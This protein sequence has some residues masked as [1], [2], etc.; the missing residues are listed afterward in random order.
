MG[1]APDQAGLLACPAG[2]SYVVGMP[3]VSDS[4]Q[5][6][7]H[8]AL[9][10]LVVSYSGTAV[11]G[12][13]P[14][15]HLGT[16]GLTLPLIL[17][18]RDHPVVQLRHSGDKNPQTYTALVAGLRMVPVLIDHASS[19]A[20]LSVQ[21]TP[22]GAQVLLGTRPRELID[23]SVHA[24]DLLGPSVERL[25]QRIEDL[26]DWPSRFAAVDA[27]LLSRRA[28]RP[29]DPALADIAWWM[30]NTDHGRLTAEALA[31]RLGSPPRTLHASMLKH[32][33]IGPK[34]LSRIARFGA[35]RQ[36]VHTR[37]LSQSPDPTL[38][39]IAAEC[40]Y[41]DEAHLIRDWKAFAG[42]TPTR[43]RHHDEHAFHQAHTRT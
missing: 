33:G 43:W 13:T 17:T 31:D 10:G 19:A 42:S 23:V 18:L 29:P 34:A 15:I 20:T 35:A 11:N 1:A 8:P 12:F 7:P 24:T 16:P 2:S 21:L 28:D 36:I 22:R 40:G 39:M 3:P 37:L 41:A 5:G 27:Y 38:A 14:G 25:R 26:H 6:R 30:I 9:E 32:V 4:A